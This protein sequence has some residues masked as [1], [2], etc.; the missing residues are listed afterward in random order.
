MPQVGVTG[1]PKGSLL[2]DD[3][4]RPSIRLMPSDGLYSILA[5]TRRALKDAGRPNVEIA[6]A[7][8]ALLLA[9]SG[10]Y[11]AVAA[12]FVQVVR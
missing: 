2:V 8:D 12:R 11:A 10:T 4:G 3:E 9:P 6:A 7:T 5:M 1:T